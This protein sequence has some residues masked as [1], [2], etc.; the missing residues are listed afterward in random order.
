M[1]YGPVAGDRFGG[2]IDPVEVEVGVDECP[3]L[4]GDRLVADVGLATGVADGAVAVDFG[5]MEAPG[6]TT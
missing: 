1:F 2:V 4:V 3:L 5:V 6:D